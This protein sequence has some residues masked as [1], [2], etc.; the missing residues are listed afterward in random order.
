MKNPTIIDI[1]VKME[2]FYGKGKMLHPTT[3][4]IEEATRTIPMGMVATIETLCKRLAKD[5]ETDVTCP[6]R[7]GNAIKKIVEKY[8][9]DMGDKNLPFWRLV[10]NDG[11]IINSKAYEYCAA[12]LEDEGFKLSYTKS[13]DIRIGLDPEKIYH[14]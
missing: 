1:P 3:Q 9:G 8:V 7:T 12:R 6:M 2:K 5:F 11:R 10:K 14:F 4:I 13:G